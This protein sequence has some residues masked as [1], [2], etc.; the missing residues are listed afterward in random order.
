MADDVITLTEEEK[1]SVIA[2]VD[3]H[4]NGEDIICPICKKK[5]WFVADNI[6]VPM[7]S[8][9]KGEALLGG[10]LYP[11]VMLISNWC[12]HTIFLNAVAIG[13]VKNMPPKE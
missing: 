13:I 4:R 2:W 8:N 1:A 7:T 10:S 3:N 5:E 11:Q 12:G 9:K 6:V